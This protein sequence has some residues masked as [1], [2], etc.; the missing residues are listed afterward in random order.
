MDNAVA[1]EQQRQAMNFPIQS[2]VAD[3][4]SRALDHLYFRRELYGLHYKIVLQI[5][6]AVLL[7]VPCDEIEIV[8][9]KVL[10][11]CMTDLVNIYPCNMEG[12]PINDKIYH[13]GVDREVYTKWGEKLTADDARDWGVPTRFIK[14]KK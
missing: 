14:A 3:A 4:M 10:P 11:E 8:H 9:D 2:L 13:L 6:D 7:E 1:A 5:H 12:I